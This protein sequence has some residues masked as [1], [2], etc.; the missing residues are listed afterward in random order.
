VNDTEEAQTDAQ[1]ADDAD[2]RF[3]ERG[4]PLADW[5]TEAEDKAAC[6]EMPFHA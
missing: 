5:M 6:E 3:W 4:F 1:F 2:L